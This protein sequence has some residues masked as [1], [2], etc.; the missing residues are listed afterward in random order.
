MGTQAAK[1]GEESSRADERGNAEEHDTTEAVT[2]QRS[3]HATKQMQKAGKAE[4]SQ[5]QLHAGKDEQHSSLQLEQRSSL[6]THTLTIDWERAVHEH[7]EFIW[8]TMPNGAPNGSTLLLKY[9]CAP[10]V[11]LMAAAYARQIGAEIKRGPRWRIRGA[12]GEGSTY[13]CTELPLRLA[14]DAP[15]RVFKVLVGEDDW[16]PEQAPDGFILLEVDAVKGH[17]LHGT[18]PYTFTWNGDTEAA[19]DDG[20]DVEIRGDEADLLP[21]GTV[22]AVTAIPE[23]FRQQQPEHLTNVSAVPLGCLAAV[24]PMHDLVEANPGADVVV[25]PDRTAQ[26]SPAEAM[27]ATH[28]DLVNAPVMPDVAV[29]DDSAAP[30]A[31]ENTL[32]SARPKRKPFVRGY[33][34][35]HPSDHDESAG[36]ITPMLSGKPPPPQ[37]LQQQTPEEAIAGVRFADNLTP[38]QV[39]TLRQTLLRFY[40][41]FGF[42]NS[43]PARLPK[44]RVRLKPGY[45]EV[46]H[47]PRLYPAVKRAALRR[48]IQTMVSAGMYKKLAA[49]SW[50]TRVIMIKKPEGS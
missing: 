26:H 33:Q 34:E 35:T 29:S 44:M 39:Q 12:F 9:D 45:C 15:L 2:T 17:T 43:Q 22:S 16:S 20:D 37:P 31:V 28:D 24:S 38:E 7:P 46:R 14:P 47:V 13:R 40:Q 36:T 19:D 48:W 32:I 6:V 50:A 5:A 10:N 8:V 41:A 18:H 42:A 1:P 49:N 11:S 25:H 27:Q 4:L 21:M 3:T 23:A 30:V